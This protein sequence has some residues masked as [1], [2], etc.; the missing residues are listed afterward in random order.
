[1]PRLTSVAPDPR[2]AGYYLV[3]VDRGRFA[4][5][6]GDAVA[7]LGLVVGEE[8]AAPLLAR[9]QE[10]ADVEAAYRAASRL[11]AARG[12]AR[13][14]LRRRLAQKQHAP[15]AV[16]A[17]L[18]RL[19][20]T[21]VLDDAR[22]AVEYAARRAAAGRGPARIVADLITQGVAR[23]VAEGAVQD[24]L[25]QEGLDPARTL[26]AVAERRAMQL[27]GLAPVARKRRLL[28]YLAR[29]GYR[30]AEARQVAEEVSR[31]DP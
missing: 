24:A 26:R 1:V 12:R 14:D 28:A 16:D 17:A 7:A 2:Q 18:A 9:L 21:G 3:E 10:L 5:L 25:A 13:G 19:E 15:R 8:L 22:F 11:L 23:G 6:P 4:S 31:K 20:A 30:G 29:R 27:A